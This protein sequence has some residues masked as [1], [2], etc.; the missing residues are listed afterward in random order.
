M[1]TSTQEGILLKVIIIFII[2]MSI[3]R[4]TLLLSA[5]IVVSEAML[6]A[7]CPGGWEY[8]NHRCFNFFNVKKYW[9]YA[10]KLSVH[11]RKPGIHTQQ[12]GTQIHSAHDKRE[13]WWKYSI[14]DRR[15]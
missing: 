6:I 15:L 12:R 5:V 3:L 13:R 10:E 9:G 14:L 11:G 1:G 8:F 7:R 2:T 4:V